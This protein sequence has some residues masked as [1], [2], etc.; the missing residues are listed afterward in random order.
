MTQQAWDE[1]KDAGK[2][3]G[4]CNVANSLAA[5]ANYPQAGRWSRLLHDVAQKCDA[6]TDVGGACSRFEVFITSKNLKKSSKFEDVSSES[7]IFD[8]FSESRGV[9]QFVSGPPYQEESK[10][11]PASQT[12]LRRI[13]VRYSE[14]KTSR[15]RTQFI[16]SHRR[17]QNVCATEEHAAGA[18]RRCKLLEP[19]NECGE[20]HIT[21]ILGVGVYVEERIRSISYNAF[22]STNAEFSSRKLLTSFIFFS[23]NINNALAFKRII[24][25]YALYF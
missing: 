2:V 1:Q 18:G 9:V 21:N 16:T 6:Q 20:K 19:H 13:I 22:L 25:A 8:D 17:V 23:L 4:G 7:A 12:P 3:K 5:A 15:T 24:G 14:M 11:K 10:G